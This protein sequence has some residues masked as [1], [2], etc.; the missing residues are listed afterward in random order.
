MTNNTYTLTKPDGSTTMELPAR[1]GT[2]GPDVLDIGRLNK[3]FGVNWLYAGRYHSRFGESSAVANPYRP[4][5]RGKT[6]SRSL[7]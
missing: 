5:E 2:L 3:E 7:I 6:C 4:K 1:T